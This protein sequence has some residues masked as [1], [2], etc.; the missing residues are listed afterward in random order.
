MLTATFKSV[1]SFS[2]FLSPAI[3]YFPQSPR[4]LPTEQTFRA[5]AGARHWAR[6]IVKAHKTLVL[7]P[8]FLSTLKE[9][10]LKRLGTKETPLQNRGEALPLWAVSEGEKGQPEAFPVSSEKLPR[11]PSGGINP[12]GRGL[13]SGD[14]HRDSHEKPAGTH[15]TTLS[16]SF[17]RYSQGPGSTLKASSLGNAVT[18]CNYKRWTH[19]FLKGSSG[20]GGSNGFDKS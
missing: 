7:S 5:L 15:S 14:T 12:G 10:M 17:L 16:T 2:W 11:N 9:R 8:A 19:F 3:G 20:K 13:E 1:N 4:R 18:T 6:C